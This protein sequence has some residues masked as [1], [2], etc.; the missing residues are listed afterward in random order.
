MSCWAH[1]G[2]LPVSLIAAA[3]CY[4]DICKL[5]MLEKWRC[6]QNA[7]GLGAKQITSALSFEAEF[8]DRLF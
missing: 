3:I 8:A 2:H 4:A 7:V 6:K 5:L 1:G